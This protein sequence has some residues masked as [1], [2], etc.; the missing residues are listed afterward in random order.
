MGSATSTVPFCDRRKATCPIDFPD[1]RR[2]DTHPTE[3]PR[4]P[5]RVRRH[6]RE[7]FKIPVCMRLDREQQF[8]YTENLSSGGLLLSSGVSLSAGMTVTLQFT[9]GRD[10]DRICLTGQVAFCRPAAWSPDV[11]AIGI[12]FLDVSASI[13]AILDVAVS[14][15]GRETAPFSLLDLRV[16]NGVDASAAGDR[17]GQPMPTHDRRTSPRVLGTGEVQ[18]RFSD[19]RA[20]KGDS[21]HPARIAN[22]SYGGVELVAQ[23]PLPP[24]ERGTL[25]MTLPSVNEMEPFTVRMEV[26]WRSDDSHRCGVA[27]LALSGDGL[28]VWQDI[29][30]R[31]GVSVSERRN[32]GADRRSDPVQAGYVSSGGRRRA[33]RLT[34]Y[35]LRTDLRTSERITHADIL[36]RKKGDMREAAR[37]TRAW[38]CDK[39][40]ETL[41]HVGSFSEDAERMRGNI[42]NFIGAAQVPIGIAGPLKIHGRHARGNFYVP[43][44]TTEATM[45]YSYTQGMQLVS[46]AGGVRTMLLKDELHMSPLFGFESLYE[47]YRFTEWLN[48]NFTRI[49]E[50]AEKT[51]R[52]G[53]LI[54]IEPYLFDRNVAV[55]FSYTTGDA[56]GL[57]I[58]TL[59]TE[60]ACR[61]IR[62]IVQPKIFHL[63][64]NFSAIKKV[65]AHNFVAGYGK[66]VVAESLIPRKLIKRFFGIDPEEVVRYS[67]AVFLATSHA[68]MKG[69]NGHAANAL[70]AMFIACGQDP[71]SVVESHICITN[72]EIH[73]KGDLYVSVKLPN[74]VL[75]TVGGGTRL[76]TQRECLSLLGCTGAGTARKFAEIVAATVLAGEV[77]IYGANAAGR[78]AQAF[79]KYRVGAGLKPVPVALENGVP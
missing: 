51:T 55:K 24:S 54:R 40:G 45:L 10:A 23:S 3:R 71:A 4:L 64:A 77:V 30:S 74:L 17:V 68:G 41:S 50:E 48:G 37:E 35:K 59:A 63:Q 28:A 21:A 14:G 43:M 15:F 76:A 26:R 31:T 47:A 32:E 29:V 12:R 44:A 46:L 8:G 1:R 69:M 20:G 7:T 75:G 9:S 33:R 2:R 62:P 36:P 39:T 78:F 66:T 70:A 6:A 13:Q 38:L 53:K 11:H 60:S 79:K 65:T 34:D 73:E 72:Y 67:Q 25:T 5:Y 22:M 42:E 52:H 19:A 18:L 49:K 27:F 16:E 56:S 57:N 61:F 58:V